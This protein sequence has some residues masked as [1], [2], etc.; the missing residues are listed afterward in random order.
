LNSI[1]FVPA[2]EILR[3]RSPSPVPGWPGQAV[4]NR[5]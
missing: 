4:E 2:D 3:D 1:A 5:A